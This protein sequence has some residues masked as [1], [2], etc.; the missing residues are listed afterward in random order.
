MGE[1]LSPLHWEL[2]QPAGRQRSA[3]TIEFDR[4]EPDSI[5]RKVAWDALDRSNRLPGAAGVL[6]Q[7]SSVIIILTAT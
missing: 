3:L 1:C 4:I 5:G 6:N 7:R 2:K